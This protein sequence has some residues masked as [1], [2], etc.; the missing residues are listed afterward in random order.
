MLGPSFLG[1]YILNAEDAKGFAEKRG[2][3]SSYRFVF[4]LGGPQRILGGLCVRK[5]ISNLRADTN[6][7][8]LRPSRFPVVLLLII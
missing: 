7:S 5:V 1:H 4:V 2:G 6:V 8:A 3:R